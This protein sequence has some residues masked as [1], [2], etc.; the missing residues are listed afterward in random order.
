[1]RVNIIALILVGFIN[2]SFGQTIR[3][4]KIVDNNLF[5]TTTGALVR[6]AAVDAPSL[7]HPILPI[8]NI[9]EE[10]ARYS[11][12]V[13]LN[14]ELSFIPVK[15]EDNINVIILY[16]KYPFDSTNF[17]TVFI[18][19]GYAKILARDSVYNLKELKAEEEFARHFKKGIWALNSALI[20]G[21]FK[22]EYSEEEILA[23]GKY[24]SEIQ[25]Q[26]LLTP[27]TFDILWE[28][29]AG[30]TIGTVAGIPTTFLAVSFTDAKGFEA[31]GVGL[32]GFYTG[33]ILGSALGVYLPAKKFNPDATYLETLSYG[34]LGAL[35]S[36]GILSVL[37][38]NKDNW[39]VY[40]IPITI[41]APLAAE[42]IYVNDID[43]PVNENLQSNKIYSHKDY[44]NSTL[45]FKKN[46]MHISF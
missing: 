12:S 7:N 21:E 27:D 34:A 26:K 1:M 43:Y 41:A 15:M 35:G 40:F 8:K 31:L 11:E 32:I 38:K 42:I 9:A 6:M 29:L 39:S 33:Y 20:S 17:N 5:E 28:I 2:C 16:K 13:L 44:Y 30:T 3:L 25:I 19:K 23:F 36:I 10:A 4:V 18:S 37:P 46:I 22:P 45:L 14:R 24:T